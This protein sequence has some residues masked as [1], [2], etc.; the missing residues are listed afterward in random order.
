MGKETADVAI[1]GA[2][3][4]GLVSA[5]FLARQGISVVVVEEKPVIGGATKT[6]YP[7][8]KAP[9]LGTSTGSYLLGVMQPEQIGRAHV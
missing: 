2:G 4:N 8:P 3:H 5:V 1:I 6:E 7:F 9:D